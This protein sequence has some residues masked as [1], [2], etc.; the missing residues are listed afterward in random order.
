MSLA[1]VLCTIKATEIIDDY[2]KDCEFSVIFDRYLNLENSTAAQSYIFL[3]YAMYDCSVAMDRFLQVCETKS[4]ISKNCLES[5]SIPETDFL[6]HCSIAQFNADVSSSVFLLL[7][8]LL[9]NN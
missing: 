2:C 4:F 7:F 1:A 8:I 5:F 3:S 6:N 9:Q